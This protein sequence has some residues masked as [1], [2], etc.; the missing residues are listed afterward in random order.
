MIITERRIV[1]GPVSIAVA[2]ARGHMG[3]A[4]IAAMENEPGLSLLGGFGRNAGEGLIDRSRALEEADVIIDFTTG[5]AAAELAA[6]CAGRG[7]PALVIGATGFEGDELARIATAAQTVPI[8]LSGNFSIGVNMLLGLVSQAAKLLP[9]EGWDIEILEA[10]HRRKLDAPSG[11]ALMLGEAAA[12]GRG[13]ALASVE[14]RARDGM[15]G[16]RPAGEI[17]FA[18]L[19]G[20]GIV[21]DHSVAFAA[22]DEV[23]TISHSAL[24]RGMFARGALCA[25]RWLAGRKPGQ[26]DM[27]HVL[28]LK[29]SAG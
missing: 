2:G 26:Y 7:G 1:K 15:T 9:A 12:E 17:G 19:R 3:R 28:G 6:L 25:A 14:R 23:V 11:T 18:V 8:V 24:D 29:Q 10:H 16:E 22:A 20:G 13:V 27:Q 21:G 4:I 5:S